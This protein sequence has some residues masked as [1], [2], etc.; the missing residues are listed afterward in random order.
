ME[1][2]LKAS[3]PELTKAQIMFAQLRKCVPLC[4]I[5]TL[6]MHVKTELYFGLKCQNNFYRFDGN[7]CTA[8]AAQKLHLKLH[9]DAFRYIID[10]AQTFIAAQRWN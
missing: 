8:E 10:T 5:C 7:L 3:E 6:N 9:L 4:S 1:Y 2:I